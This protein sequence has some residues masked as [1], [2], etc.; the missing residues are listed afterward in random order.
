MLIKMDE[1]FK[2]KESPSTYTFTY[3]Y[4]TNRFVV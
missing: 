3:L 2:S 4:I 1:N